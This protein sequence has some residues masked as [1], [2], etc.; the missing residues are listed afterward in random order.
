LLAAVSALLLSHLVH[1]LVD[2]PSVEIGGT[3]VTLALFHNSLR[4]ELLDWDPL[5]LVQE[6]HSFVLVHS[7]FSSSELVLAMFCLS[8]PAPQAQIVLSDCVWCLAAF[9]RH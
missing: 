1:D 6:C 2:E 5:L 3:A 9:E 8:A 7:L 4:L